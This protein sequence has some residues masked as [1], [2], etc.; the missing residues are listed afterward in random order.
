MGYLKKKY[1]EWKKKGKELKDKAARPIATDGGPN[2]PLGLGKTTGGNGSA[3]K[4]E[5]EEALKDQ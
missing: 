1:E 2:D 4:R 5:A 3:A